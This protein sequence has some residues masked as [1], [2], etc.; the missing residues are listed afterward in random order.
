[1]PLPGRQIDAVTLKTLRPDLAQVRAAEEELRAARQAFVASDDD[2]AEKMA[3]YS[4][5][6]DRLLALTTRSAA[7]LPAP[8]A[9]GQTN[10][11]G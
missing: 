8:L 2:R 4:A 3:A 10:L 7:L 1:M 9:Y 5:A 6:L 11:G